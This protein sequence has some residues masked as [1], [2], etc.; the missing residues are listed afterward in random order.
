ME[1][2]RR[3]VAV[4]GGSGGE[5]AGGRSMSSVTLAR[6]WLSGPPQPGKSGGAAG[7]TRSSAG[8][9]ASPRWLRSVLRDAHGYVEE[10]P[11]PPAGHVRRQDS[12]EY[13]PSGGAKTYGALLRFQDA[14]AV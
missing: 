10:D 14:D 6:R 3:Q 1:E 5:Q 13:A 2:A 7:P 12:Q 9:L 8:S 11:W 4:G